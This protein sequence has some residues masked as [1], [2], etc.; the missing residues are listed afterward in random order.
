VRVQL[1]YLPPIASSATLGGIVDLLRNFATP[2]T[3]HHLTGAR[4]VCK[5]PGGELYYDSKLDLD[6]DGSAYAAHDPTGQA[7]TSLRY[8]NGTSV[9]ADRVSYF[10]LP[11]HFYQQHGIRLGDVAA[12]IYNGRL[13]YAVF[14]DVGP[15]HRIGEGSIALHRALGHETIHHGRLH[16]VGITRDVITIVFPGSGNRTPQMPE[17]IA[18]IGRNRYSLLASCFNLNAKW[19]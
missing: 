2:V 3:A 13:A 4:Y 16:N 7:H 14:A 15:R 6:A 19:S 11:S 8:A 9:D 5:F 18:S 17:A 12:V 10:V 1:P